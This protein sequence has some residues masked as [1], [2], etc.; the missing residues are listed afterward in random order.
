MTKVLNVIANGD[1]VFPKD[2]N[3]IYIDVYTC[4]ENITTLTTT[5]LRTQDN[6]T[7][8]EPEQ[9]WETAWQRDLIIGTTMV[10]KQDYTTA[11]PTQDHATA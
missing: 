6:I 1:V 2:R 11:P 8:L 5:Q 7:S 10:S 4:I 9:I 3:H